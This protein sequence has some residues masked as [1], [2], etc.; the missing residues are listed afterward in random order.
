[1]FFSENADTN[2]V[3][4]V[5]FKSKNFSTSIG[6]IMIGDKSDKINKVYG[7]TGEP[8]YFEY[9]TIGVGFEVDSDTVSIIRIYKPIL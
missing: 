2:K 7:K 3:V 9:D 6:G 1:M 4:S 8:N 5:A